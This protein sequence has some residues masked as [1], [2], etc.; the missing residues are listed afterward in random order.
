M[1]T[2]YAEY[3]DDVT[4]I[5]NFKIEKIMIQDKDLAYSLDGIR[6]RPFD[7]SSII[8]EER[9]GTRYFDL[10]H[11]H[12]LLRNQL[13]IGVLVT[14]RKLS[15]REIG[16]YDQFVALRVSLL[17]VDACSTL[18]SGS[19][20]HCFSN[21]STYA[22][23]RIDIPLPYLHT[24]SAHQYLIRVD[25]KGTGLNLAREPLRFYDMTLSRHLPSKWFSVSF[26]LVELS[27]TGNLYVE[28]NIG[29]VADEISRRL[30]ELEIRLYLPSGEIRSAF[31][32]PRQGEL[33]LKT[34]AT[35]AFADK[36]NGVA[37]V[38]LRCMGHPFSGFLFDCSSI[39][40]RQYFHGGQLQLMSDYN[41]H[42]A[43]VRY[44]TLT[45]GKDAVS[46]VKDRR[47]E[48]TA[49]TAS[50]PVFDAS[51]KLSRK[52]DTDSVGIDRGV[53]IEEPVTGIVADRVDN[54]EVVTGLDSLTGLDNVKR[55]V[56]EYTDLARFLQMRRNA[57]LP[58]LSVPLHCL[59]LGS[60]GTGKT[61]VGKIMGKLLKDAGV[62]SSGHVVVRER[63]SLLGQNYHVESEKTLEALAEAEGGILFI[64]EAYQ[65]CQPSDPR[66][67]G[68]FVIETLLTALADESRRDWMLILGGYPE[69]MKKMLEMNPGLASRIPESNHYLFDDFNPDELMEIAVNYLDRHK[70][71]LTADAHTALRKVIE[72]DYRNRPANFGNGRYVINLLQTRILPA[73]A[74]RIVRLEAPSSEVLSIIEASD[75]PSPEFNGHTRPRHLG[76]R[77]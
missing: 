38:E 71:K 35:F 49:D 41:A 22:E 59:F 68:R 44:K 5:I 31:D 62:L 75:I 28:F 55:K 51:A 7:G 9:P 52:P 70:F 66:D 16:G 27:E 76:F 63:A 67:P 3:L 2:R 11:D 10:R 6:F 56:R 43:L 23:L 74:S 14:V 19:V 21:D 47:S 33:W 34:S 61:T 54:E 13:G 20:S 30:P 17:D 65:L 53:E 45:I 26:G 50:G 57:G 73:A 18:W 46:M 24:M 69:A 39:S 25:D 32:I 77:A 8:L 72:M 29:K 1:N 60:P 15:C 58:M 48:V 40:Q 4:H 36:S 37:F 64:D 12:L 42:K